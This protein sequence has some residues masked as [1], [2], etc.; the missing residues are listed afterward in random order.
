MKRFVETRE[1]WQNLP[2]L[3]TDTENFMPGNAVSKYG[4]GGGGRERERYETGI[5]E[6]LLESGYIN[7][8]SDTPFWRK[9]KSHGNKH[10]PHTIP[11]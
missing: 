11:A 1:H 10:Y 8:L 2:R 5:V 3:R 4:G 7:S 9:A 6:S